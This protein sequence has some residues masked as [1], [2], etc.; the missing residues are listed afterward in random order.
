[1]RPSSTLL[2][3]AIS[4][5][6]SF[7]PMASALQKRDADNRIYAKSIFCEMKVYTNNPH[8]YYIRIIF[9]YAY[10][11]SPEPN[12]PDMYLDLAPL[13]SGSFQVLPPAAKPSITDHNREFVADPTHDSMFR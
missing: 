12:Q 13:A 5:A 7:P 11:T 6:K 8:A 4:F 10:F 9:D 2:A 1:M 3:N